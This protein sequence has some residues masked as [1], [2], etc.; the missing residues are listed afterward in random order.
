MSTKYPFPSH[1]SVQSFVTVKLSDKSMY[2]LWKTQMQCL[3]KSHDMLGF[4]NESTPSGDEWERSDALVHGWILASLSEQAAVAVLNRLTSKQ[5]CVTAKHVWEQVQSMYGRH[6]TVLKGGEGGGFGSSPAGFCIDVLEKVKENKEQ[7]ANKQALYR[8]VSDGNI[9]K[10]MSILKNNK[11]GIT[12]SI[13]INNNTALHIAMT[14]K[15]NGGFLEHM[16]NLNETPLKDVQ[17]SD[18][19]TLLHLAV[20]LGNTHAAKILLGRSPDLLSVKDNNGLTPLDMILSRPRDEE[21]CLFLTSCST[22]S[23]IEQYIDNNTFANMGHEPVVNAIHYKHFDLALTFLK[24]FKTL[25]SPDVL[26][27]IAQNYP[28]DFKPI[29]LII[30]ELLRTSILSF[31][32]RGTS[33]MRTCNKLANLVLRAALAYPFKILIQLCLKFKAFYGDEWERS[34]A[35]VH[36]WILASLSEQAAVAVLNRLTSKQTCVTAKHV[37]EQVQSMYGRHET[38]LKG[39]EGGGFGSSPAGFCID[40]LEKVKENKEQSA[41]KQALYRAVS[42]GNI[43]KVMSILKNNKIGITDSISINNNTA[44]HIAMTY[45]RNGGFLEHMLNLNETPL[46]DVQNSDGSTLLHLAVSLGNTHAAKILLGRSPDLLSVKDNNGLT[47]LDMI[48]SRPRDEEMCLFL[49]SCS[50]VSDIEQY[51]DNNTFANMGHEPVVNAI[52]YK[53]FDLALTFL[54]KFK[55]LKSPDVLMAIAQNYPA[56]FKPI[57]LIIYELLRTS[58]LS[59]IARGTSDMRTCNKLANLVLRAAL[60]Y[61]FKILIQLCLKFK[62]FYGDEWERSDALV[63][64]WILASLSEQ[65]AVAVLNRLT[66]KQTCVTAKHVWE[67]VQSMYGRHETVLKGGEGGGFGSSPAGFCIDV[68]EKVK[69]NKEQSA[70]KQALYRAVSDGNIKKVM[71]I[72]K[73]N[74]IGITDSISINNNT[75]LHIAMTYKRNGGFLEHMLNLNETPLKDVQNSDGSTLL[76]LAVSLGNTHAAKILL[77][78]SPDLL[79]VKDN[80]GL[81]PLDMILSRPR[82][83]EM[84]LF[85]TSCSTVSDIEQYIDNNTFA[86]MGHEPVVNAIHYK[87]FDLALTFLKKFKTLKSPDVLMAIAQNYPAD[88]KPIQLIIYELLRTSILSFIARGTSDMRT[89]NKLA[90]LVL[91]AA[92]AYPFKILIQLCL[93]FKAFY[94]LTSYLLPSSLPMYRN[95][96]KSTTLLPASTASSTPLLVA[97][98][99]VVALVFPSHHHS[100]HLSVSSHLTVRRTAGDSDDASFIPMSVLASNFD[101]NNLK[102]LEDEIQGYP[103]II[104]W[105]ANI[106]ADPTRPLLVDIG[107]GIDFSVDFSMHPHSNVFISIFAS[108]EIKKVHCS[109]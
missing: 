50:T 39:G 45:K 56:D 53:H 84:C 90:N 37:W 25:K 57:Q 36:G 20:S 82:D 21:M 4:I 43:K 13:S 34:D 103:S 76:H 88:F 68:L 11:I 12:D 78:R 6:E 93:K 19:S 16:L 72:L 3:L 29:Q 47:P 30:Y 17:N 22:V 26:M 108:W 66:S 92:L 100:V 1:V 89:C 14:Y 31:I 55:T 27:A 15:R 7:S 33:D 32:A 9:K 58:I 106:Y 24:K 28:A 73:N 85:L 96:T 97:P 102:S 94:D 54:K 107:S 77:G 40:V 41:N 101:Q 23:D 105:H 71:S 74:K 44:L 10:V 48:L 70:N 99:A 52:H 35:L 67:Q 5:T 18:G 42:D 86:N 83:E 62:A 64:G 63:H 2:G 46:K 49:T 109:H 61:P 75:A 59:F 79:S 8:A 87:H 80:N 60:A 38:V 65:A 98:P 91:R 104:D 51:I 95:N 69:E 81:T